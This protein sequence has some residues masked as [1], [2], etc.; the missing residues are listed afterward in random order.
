VMGITFPR[1]VAADSGGSVFVADA[2]TNLLKEIPP[3]CILSNCVVTLSFGDS[4][5]L[6]EG[7]ALDP[8][9]NVYVADA[10]ADVVFEL[11]GCPT[12]CSVTNLGGAFGAPSQVAS[13]PYGNIYVSDFGPSP[14]KQGV[15]EILRNGVSFGSVAVNSTKPVTLTVPFMF[16]G[17]TAADNVTTG[18]PTVLSQGVTGLDFTDAGTGTCTTNGSHTYYANDTCTVDV[19]FN[20]R[21][22]GARY[23]AVE[24]FTADKYHSLVTTAYIYGTGTGPHVTFSPPSQTAPGGG[25][26][27]PQGVAV[28]ENGNIFVADTANNAIKKIPAK[29][30]SQNCVL[31]PSAVFTFKSPQDV[32]VDGAGNLYFIDSLNQVQELPVQYGYY[33]YKM[34]TTDGGFGSVYGLAVDASGDVYVADN[35]N[36][37]VKELPAWCSS[38]SC[39]VTLGGGFSQPRGV[40]VDTAGNVYVPDSGNGAVKEIPAGCTATKY[41]NSTCAVATLGGGFGHPAGI[42]LD[43]NGNV[44]VTDADN[45]NLKVVP[46]GCASSSCVTT[47]SGTFKSPSGVAV[48]G[49]GNVYVAD[50]GTSTIQKLDFSDAPSLTF[51]STDVGKSSSDSPQTVTVTNDGN[52]ALSF[53]SAG[54]GNNPTISP[55]FTL[56]SSSGGACPLI[57]AGDAAGTL[58]AGASCTLSISFAPDNTSDTSGSLILTDTDLNLPGATQSISLLGSLPVVTPTISWS[59]GAIAYGTS[60]TGVMNAVAMNG[61][62]VVPG[63]Y[64]YFNGIN[65]LTSSTVLPA[66]TYTLTVNFTPT[67]PGQYTTA[68]TTASLTV[69]KAALTVTP[70]AKSMTYGGVLPAL[71]GVITGEVTGDGITATYSTNATSKSDAGNT[72]VISATLQDPGGKLVNYTVTNNTAAFTVNQAPLSITASGASMVYGG[73]VPTLSGTYLGAVNGDTFTI[74]GTT[75]ATSLSPVGSYPITPHAA[76]AKLADYLVTPHNGALAISQ[77]ALTLT[78]ANASRAYATANPTFTGKFTGVVNGDTITPTYGTTAT[79]ASKVGTYSITETLSGTALVNYKPTVVPGT[80]TVSKATLNVTANGATRVYGAAN[81]TFTAAFSGFVNGDTAAKALTG[82]PALTTTATAKSPVANYPITP[83]AGTLAAANYTFKFVAGTLTVTKAS[84]TV[85]A[86]NASVPYN[87]AIPKL[88]YGVSGYLNGDSASSLTGAPSETTTAKQGSAVGTYPITITQGTLAATNYSFQFVNGALTI[89][90]L[91]TTAGPVFHP[92][93]GTYNAAV[94]VTL[95]DATG[96]A[97]FHYTTNGSTPTTASPQFPSAGIK[98]TATETLT[99]IAVAHGYNPSAPVSATYTIATAPTVTTIAATAIGTAKA[100]LNGTVVANNA[101]TQYWFA[102]GTSTSALTS[103]TSKTGAL[104]GTTSTAIS[105]AQGK[106]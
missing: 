69:N 13:D 82:S 106:C 59:P 50:Y 5:A 26:S 36:N 58:T 45:S 75:T 63:G 29:C 42:A 65:P 70:D 100:T 24:L 83:A 11:S 23:G 105:A 87:Q 33:Y 73:T 85:T 74:T 17:H 22:P 71:T 6:L 97:V 56:D 8:F 81:P 96:G 104:T 48:D 51:A 80:L 21:F 103:N 93:P 20:P 79:A 9:G 15:R 49:G 53:P 92:T 19:T 102:Y 77:A 90:S 32:A 14:Y 46:A 34:I 12:S 66:G 41:A 10:N 18:V 52:S 91:G 68:T 1:D 25:F 60:L 57:A 99:A 28:D 16:G 84:L 61:K 44:F 31:N 39:V 95:T 38:S 7:V 40:A 62:S 67:D 43:G 3:G 64:A 89:A 88:T 72:Y 78:I 35:T 55:G 94:T 27:A 2:A 47:L 54:S 4:G 98:V 76:G 30:A 37:A 101:T 86:A